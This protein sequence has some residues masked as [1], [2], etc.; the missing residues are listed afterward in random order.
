MSYT[1][2]PLGAIKVK[3][4]KTN[5]KKNKIISI[6]TWLVVL[7]L[8]FGLTQFGVIAPNKLPSPIRVFESMLDIFVNGYNFIPF[9][10]HIGISL[11]RLLLSTLLATII[12]IPLGLLSGYFDTFR[13]TI[14]S[15]V[16]FYRPLPPLAYYT[17]LIV[18]MGIDEESKVML[19]F[20]AAFAPIY[21]SSAAAVSRVNPSYIK[22]AQT[23]GAGKWQIFKTVVFPASLP[24]IFVGIRTAMGVAYTTL[25]SAEMVAARAGLGWMVL[26]AY[27]YLKT[28]VVF[29]GIIIMGLSGLFI[30]YILRLI[31]KK[32]IF[33]TGK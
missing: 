26:D 3:K 18:W 27:K 6:T 21:L 24:E 23:F 5:T 20:L 16:N 9:W 32:F 1:G 19:L 30:D 13:A 2:K 12:A 11:Y 17:L 8:W 10:N 22:S 33:W 25:V 29:V 31:E 7:L 14:N 4:M 15:L 28:D